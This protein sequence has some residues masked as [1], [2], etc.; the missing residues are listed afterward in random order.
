MLRCKGGTNEKVTQLPDK[1]IDALDFII[2]EYEKN[3]RDSP[4]KHIYNSRWKTRKVIMF[5]RSYGLRFSDRNRRELFHTGAVRRQRQAGDRQTRKATYGIHTSQSTYGNTLATGV[6]FPG[7]PH[8]HIRL[9][10]KWKQPGFQSP[11]NDKAHRQ[12][13]ST[14]FLQENRKIPC[15]LPHRQ[16][17]RR[18]MGRP[19]GNVRHPRRRRSPH[20]RTT[21]NPT[22][23][24]TQKHT[25]MKTLEEIRGMERDALEA[26]ALSLD[27]R[28]AL[29]QERAGHWPKNAPPSPK[30]GTKNSTISCGK[31][32][33]SPGFPHTT[34][35]KPGSI[36]I[37]S[38]R[39]HPK[40]NS[41]DHRIYPARP[42][43][44]GPLRIH[45]R[46]DGTHSVSGI[47]RLL[48][49]IHQSPLSWNQSTST[50]S[51]AR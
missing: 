1:C 9:F 26:L 21:Y 40:T 6:R 48:P 50:A 18:R 16:A 31:A 46:G 39:E 29:A 11:H 45:H 36:T 47:P 20:N 3:N 49:S 24:Q 51:T 19:S 28:R 42:Y 41:H 4:Q 12:S 43:M 38:V 10:R 33:F 35:R 15:P 13:I 37:T 34:V 7:A 27:T 23:R 30:A 32:I 5:F 17:C 22:R 8:S 14:V 44:V 2:D 25:P